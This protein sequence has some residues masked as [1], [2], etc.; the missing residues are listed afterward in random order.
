MKMLYEN[1]NLLMFNISK[2][3]SITAFIPFEIYAMYF[4]NSSPVGSYIY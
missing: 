2:T 3:S 4:F 1:K